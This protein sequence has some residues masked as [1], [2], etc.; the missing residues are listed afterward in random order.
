MNWRPS[1]SLAALALLVSAIAATPAAAVT[2]Q[3]AEALAAERF[4]VEVLKVR[5]G[6]VE[7][8]QVWLVTVMNP[9]AN[10]NSAFVVSTL[11]LDRASGEFLR[12]YQPIETGSL[13]PGR[14]PAGR[15]GAEGPNAE[16]P[17]AEAPDSE[18]PL[19]DLPGAQGADGEPAA[20]GNQQAGEQQPATPGPARPGPGEA[21]SGDSDPGGA[22]PEAPAAGDGARTAD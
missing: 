17:N 20:P 2:E 12:G 15:P 9:G 8:R 6:F 19:S 21:S 10:S 16:G 4:G 11:A 22:A 13:A 18:G 5:P 1:G 14:P 3:E 7:D